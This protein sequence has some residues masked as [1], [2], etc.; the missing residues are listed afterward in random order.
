MNH[1]FCTGG[2][3]FVGKTIRRAHPT[4][5]SQSRILGWKSGIP[6]TS[7]IQKICLKIPKIKK[8]VKSRKIPKMRETVRIKIFPKNVIFRWIF[9]DFYFLY[10]WDF[11]D[12][13]DSFQEKYFLRISVIKS[14][15]SQKRPCLRYFLEDS[16][17]IWNWDPEKSHPI[18]TFDSVRFF[19]TDW[20]RT[21]RRTWRHTA[22]KMSLRGHFFKWCIRDYSTIKHFR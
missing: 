17:C 20:R 18:S 14:S 11:S 15:N 22:C 6:K 12:F 3:F 13:S 8:I 7:G 2:G 5:K 9:Y 16:P 10:F 4:Q 21:L 1:S 19:R